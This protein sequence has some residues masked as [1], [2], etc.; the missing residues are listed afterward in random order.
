MPY[1]KFFIETWNDEK[2]L[3][4]VFKKKFYFLFVI[5]TRACEREKERER[6]RE[7]VCVYVLLK[8][9]LDVFY[10]DKQIITSYIQQKSKFIAK[11]KE[12]IISYN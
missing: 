2:H 3:T 7:W 4:F 12:H 5:Y 10:L 11:E 6:E 1:I 9:T 8:I